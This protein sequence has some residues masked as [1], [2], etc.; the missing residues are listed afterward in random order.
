MK[1]VL[2]YNS[3]AYV[4]GGPKNPDLFERW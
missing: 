1:I 2:K 3:F 4:Q